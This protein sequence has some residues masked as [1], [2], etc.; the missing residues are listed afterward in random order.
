LIELSDVVFKYASRPDKTVINIP[1][2]KVG[3]AERVLLHGP[4]GTGKSTFLNILS[5]FFVPN[6]GTVNICEKRLDKMHTS[7][8]DQF[9]AENIGYVFQQFNLVP[10][11]NAIE[12]VKLA[13]HFQPSKKMRHSDL[14]DI[15]KLLQDLNISKSEW[16]IPSRKLSIGQQQRVAIARAIVGKPKIL[17]ADEPTSALD[18]KNINNFMTILNSLVTSQNITLIYVSHDLNLSKHFTRIEDFSKVNIH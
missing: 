10:F 7:K 9:R 4:S 18:S 6:Y 2:W 5:G 14:D 12:N 13:M 8:R 15:K 3:T 16:L 11:L 1:N 17:I